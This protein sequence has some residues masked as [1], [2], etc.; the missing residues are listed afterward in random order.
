MQPDDRWHWEL[1]DRHGLAHDRAC[2]GADMR[3][4]SARAVTGGLRGFPSGR[5]P[6]LSCGLGDIP[7]PPPTEGCERSASERAI[8]GLKGAFHGG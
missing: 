6:R 4:Q 2:Q 3:P 5:T 1:Q 8:T 7:D